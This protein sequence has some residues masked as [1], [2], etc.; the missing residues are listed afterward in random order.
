MAVTSKKA[1]ASSEKKAA[2]PKKTVKPITKPTNSIYITTPIYYVSSVPHIGTAYTTIATDI[3]TRW[4][5][6]TGQKVYFLTGTDEHGQKIAEAAAAK[7]KTPQAFV[8]SLIPIFKQAWDKLNIRYDQFIRT[9]D[10]HHKMEVQ[11]FIELVHKQGDIYKGE[12][13]GHYCTPCES[14][15]TELQLA[16]GKC[17]ECH[18]AVKHL[19]EETYFFKLSKYQQ[20]LLDYYEQHPEF[21]APEFRKQEIINRVKDGL[22]D[23]SISRRNISWGIPFPLDKNHVT[24]VWFDALTNYISAI[25]YPD[26]KKTFEQWWPAHVHLMGK[27]ILWFHAVIWP[28]MLMSAGL[29]IPKKVFAHGWLTVDGQKMSKSV[30]NVVDP[31]ALCEKY[32]EDLARFFLFKEIPFGNDGDFSEK[33]LVERNNTLLA[34]D[35]GNYVMRIL[36]LLGKQGTTWPV[37]DAKKL[38]PAERAHIEASKIKATVA[39]QLEKLEF[40]L[41]LETIWI[42]LRQS[43]KYMQDRKPWTLSPGAEKDQVLYVAAESLRL[44]A[45]FLHPFMPDSCEKILALFGQTPP[46]ATAL[47]FAFQTQGTLGTPTVLFPKR[48][49]TV[50]PFSRLLLKVGKILSVENHPQAD[51]LYVLKVDLGGEQRQLV[52]GIK[53]YYTPE[54]LLGKKIVIVANLKPAKLRGVESQGMILAAESQ[55]TVEVLNPGNA[56]LGT[57]VLRAGAAPIPAQ[58]TID[59]FKTIVLQVRNHKVVCDGVELTAAGTPVTVTLADDATI[60]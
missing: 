48:E 49:F 2:S 29:P 12:Y 18:R 26:D 20:K 38:G 19:T 36:T 54:Q 34:D 55:G 58:I 10:A 39:Q 31:I 22:K 56:D 21:I 57:I 44:I 27:E 46:T 53:A 42:F 60:R 33:D 59:D 7:G 15:W 51:K 9:T 14:F 16:D 17:P 11:Q 40:H 8:D 43:N 25:G 4:Y 37:I 24:Y 6:L 45:S 3:L 35:L 30:G 13:S 1:V 52:A 5:Q 47:E 32:G 23:L 41:A 28:A 50:H